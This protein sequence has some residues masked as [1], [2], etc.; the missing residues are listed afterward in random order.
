MWCSA[1]GVIVMLIL[2]LLAAP[3]ATEA[4]PVPQVH[5]IGVLMHAGVPP[6]LLEAFREGLRE[7]GY[8]EGKNIT[9]ELRN[10]EGKNERLSALADELLRLE[11][12]VIL[13]VNTPAAQAAKQATATVPI[14]ITRI[15]DPVHAGLVP[16]LARPGCNVTGLSV[17]SQELSPKRMQLLKEIVPGLSRVAVLFNANNPGA[18][19]SVADMEQASSQLGRGGSAPAFPRSGQL[20]GSLSGRHPSGCRSARRAR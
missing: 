4:Q 12:H 20:S 2:S 19:P 1:I 5:C 18:F 8:V 7:L 15:A 3:L 9:L 11:V 14:V 10:A 13:A 17:N 6:G 16:S